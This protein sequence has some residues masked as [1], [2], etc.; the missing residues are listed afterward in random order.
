MS[1]LVC[2]SVAFFF[3]RVDIISFTSKKVEK[4][5]NSIV[6]PTVKVVLAFDIS[7]LL[8]Y[9]LVTIG[10]MFETSYIHGFC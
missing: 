4:D 1:G 6:Q 8:G 2:A 3:L 5:R 7:L 9:S 10:K